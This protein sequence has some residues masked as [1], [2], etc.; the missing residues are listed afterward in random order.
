MKT[1]LWNAI[2][3]ANTRESLAFERS[4]V[5]SPARK[6]QRRLSE[7]R[8]KQLR[9]GGR[10]DYKR[11]NRPTPGDIV[12]QIREERNATRQARTQT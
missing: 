10:R 8:K 7:K 2:Q 1:S 6:E 9:A 12:R 5:P 3:L 11:P 4:V